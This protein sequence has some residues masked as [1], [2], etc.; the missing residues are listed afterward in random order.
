MTARR[1][2]LQVVRWEEAADRLSAVRRTVFVHEQGVP[3]ELEIDDL[4]PSCIHLLAIDEAFAA[5][6]TGRLLPDAHIGR[7]AVLKPW[8]GMGVGSA[9]LDTL[10]VIAH[11]RGDPEAILHAQT[12][13]CGF[14]RRAGFKVTSDEFMEAGIPHV[15]MRRRLDVPIARG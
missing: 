12:H 5:I 9:I 10:L 4:D 6:G 3:E 7:M 14:Y 8:R 2:S 15:E 1:F 11:E 13:A